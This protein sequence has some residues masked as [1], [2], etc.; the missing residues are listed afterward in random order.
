MP[1]DFAC[2]LCG[3]NGENPRAVYRHLQVAHEKR[4]IAMALLEAKP[5]TTRAIRAGK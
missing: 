3:H 4:A 2:P 5:V 1:A